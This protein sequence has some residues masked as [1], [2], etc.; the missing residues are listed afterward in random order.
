MD[1]VVLE[2]V[3]KKFGAVNAVDGLNVCVPAGS[4]YGFLGPNGAGKTTLDIRPGYVR[5]RPVGQSVHVDGAIAG[6]RSRKPD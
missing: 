6:L 4:I 3:H 5:I 2:D 1:A